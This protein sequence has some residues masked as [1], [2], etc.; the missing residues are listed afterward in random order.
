[1]EIFVGDDP[2]I[3]THSFDFFNLEQLDKMKKDNRFLTGQSLL[4]VI[5]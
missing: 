5:G 2:N 1:M 4:V 3:P